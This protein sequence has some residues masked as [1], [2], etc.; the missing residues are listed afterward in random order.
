[1]AGITALAVVLIAGG[2]VALVLSSRNSA[3]SSSDSKGARN[4]LVVQRARITDHAAA[5]VAGQVSRHAVVA[6]DR[7]MCDALA[8]H[9]FP[10]GSLRTVA[11]KATQLP[12]SQIVVATPALEQQFGKQ[13]DTKLAPVV[14]AGF[15]KTSELTSIRVI[16]PHGAAAYLGALRVDLKLRQTV[17]TGLIT[18]RQITA[19]AIARKMMESGEVDSRLLI[20]ITALAAQRPID[21]LSFGPADAGASPGVPVRTAEL[22]ETTAGVNLT[23]PEY[24]R[25]MEELLKVQPPRYRPASVSTVR[26]SAGQQVLKIEFPAPSPLGLLNPTQ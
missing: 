3:V 14:L 2:T 13:L 8:Q 10:A 6:C 22:A 19:T 17:G 20:V 24:V 15:G 23:E 11:A 7:V 4:A 9:G 21:I 18:S 5:W 16:T 12:T 25:A 26:T 1:M